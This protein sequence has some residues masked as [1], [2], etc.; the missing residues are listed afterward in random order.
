MEIFELLLVGLQTVCTDFPDAR[1]SPDPK[2]NYSMADIGLSAY[3]WLFIESESFLS[4]QQRLDKGP[5]TSNCHRLLGI[6]RF[7]LTTTFV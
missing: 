7:R 4:Y 5:G 2:L 6:T 1:C 3:S